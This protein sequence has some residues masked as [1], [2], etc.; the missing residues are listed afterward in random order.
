MTD[1]KLDEAQQKL[2]DKYRDINVEWNDWHE[3]VIEDF[4]VSMLQDNYIHVDR[5]HFSGF[6]SQGDGACF[7]GYVSDFPEYMDKH[8]QPEQYPMVRKLLDKG[9]SVYF[10][11]KHSGHY[12]HEYCVEYGYGADRLEDVLDT[13]SEVQEAAIKV[14]DEKLDKELDLLEE[15]LKDTFRDHMRKLYKDLQEQ[16]EYYTSDKAIWE[17]IVANELNQ[18]LNNQTTDEE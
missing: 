5:V 6:W 18:E 10:K 12:Y 4:K 11:C 14:L 16:Y 2:V 15:D 8:Y 17:T 3:S 13:H 9:G 7:E 1:L